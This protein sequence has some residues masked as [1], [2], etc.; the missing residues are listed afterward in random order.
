EKT[1]AQIGHGIEDVRADGR[2]EGISVDLG[3]MRF[4]NVQSDL[5]LADGRLTIP[6]LS[7]EFAGGR[8]LRERNHLGITLLGEMPIDGQL[9]ILSADV[10]RLLG[11]DVPRMR[12]LA[13]R[14]D[15]DVRFSGRGR[16]LFRG[17]G[18]TSLEA[19]GKVEVHDAKLWTI[20][21]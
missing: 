4:S 5:L 21:L 11:D 9:E 20:P 18:L 10:S 17:Q 15:A 3:G 1:S 8:L 12:G 7:A 14:V 6:W 2:L 19:A 16:P 13:G